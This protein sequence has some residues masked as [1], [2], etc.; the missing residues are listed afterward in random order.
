MHTE[1]QKVPPSFT[2]TDITAIY[3]LFN[4]IT[5][6]WHCI[7]SSTCRDLSRRRVTSSGN[8]G[9]LS[10]VLALG[11]VLEKVLHGLDSVAYFDVNV[12]LI[13]DKKPSVVRYHPP[14]I[15]CKRGG[16]P[17]EKREK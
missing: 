2:G 13:S 14:I 15:E 9:N 7:A 8:H 11:D 3:K 12:A 16:G 1:A 6:L 17:A 10:T 4:F 5:C